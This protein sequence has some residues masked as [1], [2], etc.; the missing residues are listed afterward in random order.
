MKVLFIVNMIRKLSISIVFNG[1]V[2][3]VFM[4][5]D[6]FVLIIVMDS[7]GN[8]LNISIMDF[9]MIN[10]NWVFIIFIVLKMMEIMNISISLMMLK[11]INVL[12]VIVIFIIILVFIV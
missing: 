2:F 1:R 4:F 3:I 5:V 12:F 11:M 10:L 9:S 8:K 7:M 6:I